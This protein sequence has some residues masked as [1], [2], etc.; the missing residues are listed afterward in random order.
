MLT[1]KRIEVPGDGSCFFHAVGLQV[2]LSAR[3]LRQICAAALVSFS[4]VRFNDLELTDWIRY[5]TGLSVK[6]Y[7]EQVKAGLWGGACEAVILSR[8][9]YRPFVLYKLDTAQQ[10]T[11][12]L[13]VGADL[14]LRPTVYLLWSGDHYSALRQ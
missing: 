7:S 2:G 4:D 8:V 10:A 5:D 9:L 14:R 12:L 6:A 3:D 11:R 1:F 13:S